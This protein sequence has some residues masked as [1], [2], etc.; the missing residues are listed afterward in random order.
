MPVNGTYTNTVSTATW[1]QTVP[2]QKTADGYTY[3]AILSPT[4]VFQFT[5]NQ[6]EVYL[7]EGNTP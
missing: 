4:Q 1:F 6:V 2:L 5:P 7:K 3:N